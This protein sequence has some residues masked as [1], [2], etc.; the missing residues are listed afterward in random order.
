MALHYNTGNASDV[1]LGQKA[2]SGPSVFNKFIDYGTRSAKVIGGIV[3]G[4]IGWAGAAET[5][6]GMVRDKMEGKL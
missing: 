3:E 6:G 4:P 2:R 1:F 5:F